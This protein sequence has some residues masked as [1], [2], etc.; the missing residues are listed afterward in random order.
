MTGDGLA[1]HTR[2]WRIYVVVPILYVVSIG[3]FA[4]ICT[5]IRHRFPAPLGADRRL[6]HSRLSNRLFAIDLAH[7]ANALV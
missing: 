5:F 4:W 1:W 2:R 7:D 6:C 3:S